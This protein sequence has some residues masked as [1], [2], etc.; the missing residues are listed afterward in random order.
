MNNKILILL[1]LLSL[2]FLISCET[3]VK[4]QTTYFGGKIINPK[5][6]RVILYSMEQVIDTFLLDEHQKF[7]GEL[8]NANEGLYYFVHGN[9]NQYIYIEPQD[10]LMLRLNT[11]DFDETL[12]FAGKG[13]DRNN[14]LI[15]CFLADEKERKNFYQLNKQ[16]VDVFKKVTDSLLAT[17]LVTYNDYVLE[18]P[19]ETEGFNEVLKVALTFPIYSRFERYPIIHSKY[20]EDGHFPEVDDSFYDYRKNI[21][22][23]KDTM[24]YFPPYS[25][26]IRNYLYNETYAL[27]HRPMR[28]EYTP[29]FT[30][31][32]LNIIDDRITSQSTKNAFLKQTLV[33]HFYNK[34]SDQVNL[35]AFDLFLKSS[36]N[37]KDKT[38]I[39]SLLND[40]KAITLGNE[41]PNFEIT[42]Y[43]NS[44]HSIHKLIKDK[45]TFL[46]FWNPE[47]V[48]KSYL[49][50][51]LVYLQEKFPNIHFQLIKTDGLDVE[52]IEKLDIKNQF[53]INKDNLAQTFLSSK[54][55][56]TILVNHNG[57]VVNGF[58]SIYSN[59]L[60][61]YLEDL[62]NNQ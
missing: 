46:L 44:N 15:D 4:E 23:D 2:S 52:K 26:Y 35:E 48:S 12:S 29:D 45:N 10:S 55:T 34:S 60:I 24:M 5:S 41:L 20:A 51:R 6:N 42:D 18:H 21:D 19:D 37:E 32:L 54:M 36:T 57:K 61:P 8:K 59:N 13:A 17:K 14:M 25:R 30:L 33:S 39:Q 22:I 11:W 40:S 31:D 62:N 27:G 38:Q 28:N 58:A 49:S 43:T 47:Y 16:E 53:Y 9:E 1:Q 7:I 3:E 50:S 56:R